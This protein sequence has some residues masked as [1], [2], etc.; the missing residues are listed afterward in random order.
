MDLSTYAAGYNRLYHND[1]EEIS[2]IE[3]EG[4]GLSIRVPQ[5]M[6]NYMRHWWPS[7]VDF[8]AQAGR[9]AVPVRNFNDL[10]QAIRRRHNLDTVSWFGH[11]T[12]G[13]EMQFGNDGTSFGMGNIAGLHNPDVSGYFNPNGRIIIY[14]CNAGQNRAFGQALANA[15]RVNI[16]AFS[17]GIRWS[18]EWAPATG[19][20]R[21]ITYRG[22]FNHMLPT[23][24]TCCS[25]Q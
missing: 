14:G 12:P 3:A 20:H 24:S 17:T 7:T 23:N 11:A 10:L 13:G 2:V 25:P 15:L 16:C 4:R 8:A 21:R 6:N 5:D 22:V 19:P 18:V 9:G 1:E